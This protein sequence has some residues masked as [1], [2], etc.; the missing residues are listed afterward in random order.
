MKF[1]FLSIILSVFILAGCSKQLNIN[2]PE[3]QVNREWLKVAMEPDQG[4]ECD[5]NASKSIDGAYGGKI[6]LKRVFFSNGKIGYMDVELTI[7]AGAFTGVKTISYTVNPEDAALDFSPSMSFNKNLDLDYKLSGLDLSS[8]TNP[9]LIDFV[10][11]DNGSFV[12]TSYGSKKVDLRKGVLQVLNAKIL[13]FSRYG[14]ATITD[15]DPEDPG[16][17]TGE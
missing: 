10:Y 4:V 5:F 11:V 12:L 7:P 16:T 8:Y 15:P 13:H 2:E 14:W 6:E 3:Q 9:D 17:G 1:L